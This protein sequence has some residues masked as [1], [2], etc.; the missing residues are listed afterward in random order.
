MTV[1][2]R[3]SGQ[4]SANLRRCGIT[5]ADRSN[6]SARVG[7]GPAPAQ[8]ADHE[9]VDVTVEHAV[10]VAGLDVR[11]QVLHHLVGLQDVAADLAPPTDLGRLSAGD[12]V[13]LSGV[14][15]LDLG[16]RK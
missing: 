4:T 16:D 1:S 8:I 13:E 2:L 3:R 14:L 15:L 6:R 10:D 7:L 9:L 12:R 11:T 5:N